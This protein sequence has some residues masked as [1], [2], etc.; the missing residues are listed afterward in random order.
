MAN[1]SPFRPAADLSSRRAIT[2]EVPEFLLRAFECRLAEANAGASEA[3]QVELE[4]LI[5]M[6]LADSLTVA[7]LAHLEREVPGI[8]AAVSRWLAEIE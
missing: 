1:I 3:E 6:Q 5:E 8:G 7:D 2:V 4:H